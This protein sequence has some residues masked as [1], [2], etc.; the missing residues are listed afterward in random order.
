[1]FFNSSSSI[2]SLW[3]TESA[4]T[5][6]SIS[7]HA[8]GP[9]RVVRG[10][11]RRAGSSNAPTQPS[12]S[13]VSTANP[14]HSAFAGRR[15]VRLLWWNRPPTPAGSVS[16]GWDVLESRWH[17]A[18]HVGVTSRFVVAGRSDATPPRTS[19]PAYAVAIHPAGLPLPRRCLALSPPEAVRHWHRWGRE[20]TGPWDIA[21]GDG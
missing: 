21:H 17:F 11:R 5:S 9:H 15:V 20:G 10:S 8:T 13:T 18:H 19:P 14:A 4:E 3:Q 1:M 16:A 2:C 12:E 6:P 7:S